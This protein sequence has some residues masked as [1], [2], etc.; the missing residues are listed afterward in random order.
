MK[1]KNTKALITAYLAVLALNKR[2]AASISLFQPSENVKANDLKLNDD[3][4][5]VA[6]AWNELWIGLE[7]LMNAMLRVRWV[8]ANRMA[9]ETQKFNRDIESA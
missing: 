6:K 9:D 4:L 7:K 8:D 3:E 1:K 5:E 2:M